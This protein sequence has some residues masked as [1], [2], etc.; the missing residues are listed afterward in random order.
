MW[1]GYAWIDDADGFCREPSIHFRCLSLI[2]VGILDLCALT[3]KTYDGPH[4]LFQVMG[5]DSLDPD[6]PKMRPLKRGA[7][8]EMLILACLKPLA[9]SNIAAP[10]YASDASTLKGGSRSLWRTAQ[11]KA[12]NPKLQSRTYALCRIKDPFHEEVEEEGERGLHVPL[13]STMALLSCA[14]EQGLLQQSSSSLARDA[15]RCL[16]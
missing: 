3:Q 12:K 14:E 9:A 11:K 10:F 16:I 2:P 8:K 4:Q 13:A 7:A 1:A 15:A 6:S 5:H